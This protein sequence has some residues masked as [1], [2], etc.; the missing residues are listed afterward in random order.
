MT[1]PITITLSQDS[2]DALSALLATTFDPSDWPATQR[3]IQAV[4]AQLAHL[5]DLRARLAP[6]ACRACGQPV[7]RDHDAAGAFVACGRCDWA[8]RL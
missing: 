5:G 3:T 2:A 7:T 4:Q 1:A 8:A 6:D